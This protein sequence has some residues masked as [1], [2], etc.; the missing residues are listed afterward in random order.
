MICINVM[1]LTI[2]DNLNSRRYREKHRDKYNARNRAWKKKWNAKNPGRL[3]AAAL[4]NKYGNGAA[5]HLKNQVVRQENRCA[6]C[7][8]A[9]ETT[10]W[11]THCLDHDHLTHQWR[12][13]LC[14]KCNT[15]IAM[16][17]ENLDILDGAKA[18]LEYWG[19]LWIGG[20]VL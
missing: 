4:N 13:A 9:F 3:R 10:R 15:L 19:D 8:K 12:G 17:C 11:K 14:R 18:Y 6:I 2:R 5:E 20:T 7:Q 1:T 16:C